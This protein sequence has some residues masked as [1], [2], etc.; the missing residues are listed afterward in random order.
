MRRLTRRRRRMRLRI[1]RPRS[2]VAF[3][4]IAV[5]VVGLVLALWAAYDL[6][7]ARRDLLEARLEL[8]HSGELLEGS[9]E[10]QA[11]NLQRVTKDAV[12]RTKRAENRLQRDPALR[13][14][15][16]VPG[17][18]DQRRGLMAAVDVAHRAAVIADELSAAMVKQRAAFVVRDAAVN[19]DAVGALAAAAERA[20]R[21][22]GRLPKTHR[23]SQWWSLGHA[24]RDLDHSVANTSDRLTTAAST[25]RVARGLL[26]GDGPRRLFIAIQ[27]N[28]EMRDQGMVLSYAVAESSGGSFRVVHG[29]SVVEL[30]LGSPVTDV[31]LPAGT[32]AVFGSLNP[33]RLWQSVNATADTALAGQLMRSMYRAATG[34]AVDGT[35]AL[36]VPALVSLLNV[37][38]PVSVPGF[39]KPITARNAP[40]VLLNDLYAQADNSSAGIEARRAQLAD[41]ATAVIN[42]LQ[43]GAINSAALVRALGAAANGRHLAVTSARP[44]EQEALERAGLSGPVGNVGADRTLHIAVQNGTANKLDWFVSPSVEITVTVTPDGT[45]VIKQDVTV[46][47]SA[48][49]PTP[50]S[51]QFGPDRIVTNVAGLYRARVYFWGPASGDQL[52]SVLE[53]GLRLNYIT[54]EVP[55]GSKKTVTLS[56]TIPNAV[57]DG[58]LRL[59]FVPQPRVR[60]IK[61]HVSVTGLGWR[62]RNAPAIPARWSQTLDLS[63]QLSQTSQ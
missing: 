17:L 46:P 45:A 50:E 28:A 61:L 8:L 7:S 27:N 26:G 35:I 15:A 3:I 22:L 19:L 4:L 44:D 21:G 2:T 53:S 29:G 37:T 55:A 43:T 39:A 5:T 60:P 62:V 38:G 25:M 57:V 16:F 51:E 13:L 6:R 1:R 31:T 42:R 24:T 33:T 49:V 9:T 12:R 34:T 58:V 52:N 30:A 10:T 14:A 47:N 56:T 20:G 63:W 18:N 32:E 23:S 48:P 59:R 36:D 11:R 41:V 40:R 54:A